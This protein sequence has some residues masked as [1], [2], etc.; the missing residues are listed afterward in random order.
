M[1]KQVSIVFFIVAFICLSAAV[2]AQ[3]NADI[4]KELDAQYKK[5]A[6]AHDRK[7]LKAIAALKTSDFHAIFVDGK[8][9]DAKTMEQYSKQFLEINL[10]PINI[11]FN[12]QKLTVS[13]NKLNTVAEI[14][15]EVTRFQDL[16][17]KR[18]KVETSTIQRQIW[19]KTPKGWRL[20]LIDELRDRKRFVDGKRIDP[21]KPFNPNDAP[22]VPSENSQFKIH[23]KTS[24]VWSALE[25][26]Y[27]QTAE[28]VINKDLQTTLKLRELVTIE[29]P[30]GKL[31][32]SAEVAESTKAQFKLNQN[33]LKIP[34]RFSV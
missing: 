12:I 11:K 5:L 4:R 16:S 27:K 8:V 14:F 26:Y 18:R 6:E 17:G 1:K 3:D 22:F 23:D 33:I 25:I 15:Q 2:F 19:T 28:A 9:G 32:P 24:P 7:D 13:E 21:A 31:H 29:T 30:D 34:T 20:K 10:S